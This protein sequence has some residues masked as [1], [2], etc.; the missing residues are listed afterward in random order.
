MQR[1]ASKQYHGLI[2]SPPVVQSEDGKWSVWLSIVTVLLKCPFRVQ[3]ATL[4]STMLAFGLSAN[5]FG[6]LE[7]DPTK[8]IFG[9]DPLYVFGAATV[10]CAGMSSAKLVCS[11][12]HATAQAW[13]T[14]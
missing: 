13:D 12:S 11:S 3:I 14:C 6:S 7:S 5:Y 10:A 1:Q 8:P 4:P 2:I 9:V